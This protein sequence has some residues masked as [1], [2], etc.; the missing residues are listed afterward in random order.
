MF[1]VCM[2]RIYICLVTDQP[3]VAWISLNGKVII[4]Y[5]SRSLFWPLVGVRAFLTGISSPRNY[6]I[7]LFPLA[8]LP[9]F[10]STVWSLDTPGSFIASSRQKFWPRNRREVCAERFIATDGPVDV[11]W[12]QTEGIITCGWFTMNATVALW[13]LPLGYCYLLWLLMNI[14]T[15][16]IIYINGRGSCREK[17]FINKYLLLIDFRFIIAK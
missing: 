3:I 8:D 17:T 16:I 2:D 14:L 5:L 12:G 7:I 4:G 9:L 11:H 6:D 15:I 1:S 13:H 10:L